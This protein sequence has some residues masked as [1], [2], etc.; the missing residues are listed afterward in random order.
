MQW[1]DQGIVIALKRF[2]EN[3]TVATLLTSTHGRHLGIVRLGKKAENAVHLGTLYEASW[4][5]RLSEH[6]GSWRLENI[7]SSFATV[8]QDPTRLEALNTAC[9][10]VNTTL[11]ERE[12]HKEVFN[13]LMHFINSL[14]QEAWSWALIDLEHMLLK[15]AGIT[16]DFSRC[17][18]TGITHDLTF[19]S[20]RTGRA[21]SRN[22]ALPYKDRLLELPPCLTEAKSRD[23]PLSSKELLSVLKLNEYFLERYLFGLHGLQLPEARGRLKSRLARQCYEMRAA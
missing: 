21:V 14:G 8:F 6:L 9:S 15:Y 13:A 16:L 22:A 19:L 4:Y 1:K 5:A 2:G 17:A 23:I 7:Y 18:A 3:K 10:L 20:P 12:P 11:P